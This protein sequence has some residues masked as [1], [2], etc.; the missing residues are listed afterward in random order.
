[1]KKADGCFKFLVVWFACIGAVCF[2]C[3]QHSVE[4]GFWMLNCLGLVAT[5]AVEAIQEYKD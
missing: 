5:I 3:W 4:A 2:G 1:M